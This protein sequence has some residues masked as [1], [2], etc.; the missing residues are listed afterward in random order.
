MFRSTT[1][2]IINNVCLHCVLVNIF[3]AAYLANKILNEQR[4]TRWK[5]K[6]LFFSGLLAGSHQK[7]SEE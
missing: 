6:N 2:I 5:C 4:Q 3:N 1:N 7:P